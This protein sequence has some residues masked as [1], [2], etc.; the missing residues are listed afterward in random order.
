MVPAGNKAKRI[1]SVNHATKTIHHHH[2]HHQRKKNNLERNTTDYGT[3][4]CATWDTMIGSEHPYFLTYS[5]SA[6]LE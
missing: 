2:H 5:K 3:L 6:K 1:S 4:S